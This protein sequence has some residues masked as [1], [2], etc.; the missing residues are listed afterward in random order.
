MS[1]LFYGTRKE[2]PGKIKSQTE[3]NQQAGVVLGILWR[4]CFFSSYYWALNMYQIHFILAILSMECQEGKW[5]VQQATRNAR[6]ESQTRGDSEAREDW[7][8]QDRG[9][10]S[11]EIPHEILKR[12]TAETEGTESLKHKTLLCDIPIVLWNSLVIW[13][14]MNLEISGGEKKGLMIFRRLENLRKF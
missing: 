5:V 1:V 7:R 2:K 6:W 11:R 13:E 9:L 12:T 14:I 4:N 3:R 8:K 10:T